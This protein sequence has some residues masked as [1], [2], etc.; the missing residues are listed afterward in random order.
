MYVRGIRRTRSF[1][2]LWLSICHDELYLFYFLVFIY[3]P[4]YA[5]IFVSECVCNSTSEVRTYI[6][7]SHS[8]NTIYSM[9]IITGGHKGLRSRLVK[10]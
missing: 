6:I 7:T 10:V 9:A 1:I 3:E 4:L 2:S 5:P 8:W